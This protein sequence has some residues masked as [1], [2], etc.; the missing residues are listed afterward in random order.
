MSFFEENMREFLFSFVKKEKVAKNVYSFY[1][2]K[3]SAPFSF[4]PGQYTRVILDLESPDERGNYRFFTI[5]SAPSEEYIAITTRIFENSSAFKKRLMALKKGDKAL[6][7]EPSGNFVLP[8]NFSGKGFVFL[9]GGVGVTPFRSMIIELVRGK[10]D[11]AITLF[12]SFSD[13]SDLIFHREFLEA[14]K[15]LENF[16]YISTITNSKEKDW[17]GERG[18]IDKEKMLK[19]IKNPKD[20]LFYIAGPSGFV[21]AMYKILQSLGIPDENKKLDE[22]PGY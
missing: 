7:E 16:S 15:I 13:T 6:F 10:S 1:F 20:F 12:A 11:Q 22:F 18:R 8:G 3:G 4:V 19:Y 2:D 9:A 5:S 21:S 14:E 17:K